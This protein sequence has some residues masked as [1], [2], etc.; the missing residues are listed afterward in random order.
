MAI[1]AI[2]DATATALT[3]ARRP[4][5]PASLDNTRLLGTTADDLRTQLQSG[6]TLDDLVSAKG[7]SSGDLISAVKSDLQANKPAGAPDLSDDQ[8]TQMATDVAAGKGPGR[9]HGH[10]HHHGAGGVGGA[11]DASTH[12]HGS[13]A[14][15]AH[16]A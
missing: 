16:S 2:N 13:A 1:S 6:K 10:H 3:P 8:L 14:S 9:A 12:P 4:P 15:P 5:Q 7:I 11:G